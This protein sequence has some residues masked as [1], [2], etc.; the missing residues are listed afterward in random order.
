MFDL[1]EDTTEPVNVSSLLELDRIKDKIRMIWNQ[2]LTAQF[3]E[4]NGKSHDDDDCGCDDCEH[5]PDLETYLEEN[6]IYFP[7]DERP[8]NEIDEL[9]Q[10]LDNLF[11][12]KEELDPVDSSGEAPN[13]S[14]SSL[15]SVNEGRSSESGSYDYKHSKTSTPEDIAVVISNTSYT[16]PSGGS[17]KRTNTDDVHTTYAPIIQNIIEELL[18]LEDRQGI[19]RRRQLYRG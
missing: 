17:I 14:G 15:K 18:S 2:I 1:L 9:I 5:K 7:D 13:Y 3:K 4:E 8:A 6:Q 11:D 12:T 16:T 10:T 19:G